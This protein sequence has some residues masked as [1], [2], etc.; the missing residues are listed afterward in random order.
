MTRITAPHTVSATKYSTDVT[1]GRVVACKWVRLACQRQLDDLAEWQAG[2]RPDWEFR[3]DE[4]ERVCRFIEMLPHVKG[5]WAKKRELIKLEPWQEFIL[6]TVFGWYS[7]DADATDGWS[8]RFRTSYTSVARKNAKTTIGSGLALFAGFAEGEEG[9]E[10]YSGATGRKQ[11]AIAW[12]I[13]HQMVVKSPDLQD[14]YGIEPRAHRI[15]SM[16]SGSLFEPVSAE[17]KGLEGTNPHFVLIDE[18]H[19]HK[20]TG[21]Y[22]ALETGTGSR[23]QPLMKVITTAGSNHAGP[24][25]RMESYVK[26]LLEGRVKDETFFGIIY[27]LDQPEIADEKAVGDDWTDPAV[28]IKANPNLGVSVFSDDI[29]RVVNQ[30]KTDA[31]KE[32]SVKRKRLN[33]WVGADNA[34]MNMAWW[35]ACGEPFDLA[36]FHGADCFLAL[37]LA[38]RD[39]IAALTGLIQRDDGHVFHFG[40]YFLPREVVQEKAA[41][42]HQNYAVWAATGEFVLTDGDVIDFDAIEDEVLALSKVFNVLEVS[43]D[44]WQAAKT[45]QSLAKQGATVVEVK[46]QVATFSEAMKEWGALIRQRKYHHGG[47]SPL[48]WMV[49]NVVAHVDAKDNIYPRKESPEKKIDGAITTLMNLYRI[50][51][52]AP[53]RSHIDDEG[54]ELMVI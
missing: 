49:G 5:R 8:R 47:D 13:G 20:D 19:A 18:Y 10:V 3:Y 9:A 51:C 22:D 37:D 1:E 7:E 27:T 6:T 45:A 4:A 50:R 15:I 30:A 38:T 24:C 12:S 34:W 35:N 11:A 41:S 52:H 2:N 29:Q 43:Y 25:Y 40:R 33:L 54:A 17:V 14:E 28:W 46:P 44:P 21:V 39:D 32:S 42:T 36:E 53:V 16:E 26:D 31:I 48:T 23:E